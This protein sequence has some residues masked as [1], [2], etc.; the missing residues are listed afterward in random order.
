[1]EVL[2]FPDVNAPDLDQGHGIGQRALT[3]A[4]APFFPF[5]MASEVLFAPWGLYMH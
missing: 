3:F 1:M 4:P 5:E 2:S